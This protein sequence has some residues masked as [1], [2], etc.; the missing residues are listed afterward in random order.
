MAMKT[1]PKKAGK[2][3]EDEEVDEVAPVSGWV[4]FKSSPI[5]K[6]SLSEIKRRDA[7]LAGIIDELVPETG[8]RYFAVHL[9]GV[10]PGILMHRYNYEWERKTR[11]NK[12]YPPPDVEAAAH[13]YLSADGKELVIPSDA[14]RGTMLRIAKGT[15]P[16]G[17]RGR[18]TM[19][20]YVAGGLQ[21]TPDEIP[22]GLKENQYSVDARMI[23]NPVTGGR[24][25]RGRAR[26]DPWNAWFVLSYLVEDMI[27]NPGQMKEM[28]AQAGRR[29]GILDFRPA[30]SGRFGRFK[31]DTFEEFELD[32]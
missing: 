11:G 15:K 5:P 25:V 18:E 28:L 24:Q 10:S 16:A 2:A 30:N 19:A 29:I 4:D 7:R 20:P 1:K 26:V 3:T 27:D 6:R 13:R 23:R 9:V 21:F 32:G 12:N 22:L 8:S 17:S 14:I 31:V